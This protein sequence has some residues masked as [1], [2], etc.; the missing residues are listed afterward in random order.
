MRG[1]GLITAWC[2]CD[3]T[4]KITPVLTAAHSCPCH[5]GFGEEGKYVL[6]FL[7]GISAVLFSPGLSVNRKGLFGLGFSCV[8]SRLFF[9]AAI[10]IIL[11]R[12]ESLDWNAS[13]LTSDL[14]LQNYLPLL[15]RFH[16]TSVCLK[17]K[18]FTQY[19]MLH[20]VFL[21]GFGHVLANI[22]NACICLCL[23]LCLTTVHITQAQLKDILSNLS[24]SKQT[25]K[26]CSRQFCCCPP[27]A[28][29]EHKQ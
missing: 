2:D 24:W 17:A 23:I 8:R 29:S 25:C 11:P 10:E 21:S 12:T 13:R 6:L 27:T 18:D 28:P 3:V 14:H 9:P 7:C 26:T 1:F 20:M 15:I 4:M 22:R 19:L 16:I 5:G